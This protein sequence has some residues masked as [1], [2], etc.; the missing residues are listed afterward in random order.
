MKS[1]DATALVSPRL[2]YELF[3]VLMHVIMGIL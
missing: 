2:S 3:E 1:N